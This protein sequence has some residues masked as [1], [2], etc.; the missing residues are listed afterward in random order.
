MYITYV[1]S[2]VAS[3]K[4]TKPATIADEDDATVGSSD[5]EHLPDG[6]IVS[7][8]SSFGWH[9]VDLRTPLPP[10]SEL[11]ITTNGYPIGVRDGKRVYLCTARSAMRFGVVERSRE[12]S[13]HYGAK[14]Y[15]CEHA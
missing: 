14:L 12:F 9:H 13:E 6:R 7:F 4:I 5:V 11:S 1:A 2:Y 3:G 10:L 8:E 15:V